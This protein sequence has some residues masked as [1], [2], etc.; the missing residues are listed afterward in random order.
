MRKFRQ[1][2]DPMI[3]RKYWL[4]KSVLYPHLVSEDSEVDTEEEEKRKEE[5]RERKKRELE[6]KKR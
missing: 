2:S 6:E 4:K 5:R 3:R 1:S